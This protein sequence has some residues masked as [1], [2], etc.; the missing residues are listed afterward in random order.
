MS[1]AALCEALLDASVAALADC[2]RPP[3]G[4]AY[5]Y[6]GPNPR[7]WPCQGDGGELV[8]FWSRA[9]VTPTRFGSPGFPEMGSFNP[10]YLD[11]YVRLVRCFPGMSEQGQPAQ[12]ADSDL[13]TAGLDDDFDCL[14]QALAGLVCSDTLPTSGCGNAA[15]VDARPLAARGQTAGF[16]IHLVAAPAP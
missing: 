4:R 2:E 3:V 9:F 5:R 13:A 11:V 16:E 14:W 15:L 7:I 1:T 6:Q 8:V 12:W 10:R